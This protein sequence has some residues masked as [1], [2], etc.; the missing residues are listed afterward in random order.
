[1]ALASLHGGGDLK[2]LLPAGEEL[3]AVK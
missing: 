2:P 1:M 3:I